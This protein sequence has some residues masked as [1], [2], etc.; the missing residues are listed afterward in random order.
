MRALVSPGAVFRRN[1]PAVCE[2]YRQFRAQAVDPSLPARVIHVDP[3]DGDNRFVTAMAKSLS[4]GTQSGLNVYVH[5]SLATREEIS[6]SDFDALAILGDELFADDCKLAAIARQLSDA[7]KYM[8]HADPLQHHGW[9]VLTEADLNRY[10]EAYF[11]EA[12]FQYSRSLLFDRGRQLTIRKRDS[13]LEMC[14]AFAELAAACTGMLAAGQFLRNAYLTKCVLS[15]FMLLPSL[16]VQA[17]HAAGIYKKFSFDRARRDFTAGEWECMDRV[18]N[19]RLEWDVPMGRWS[20]RLLSVTGPL[21]NAIVRNA[22]PA[23]PQRL[24]LQIT[25]S[26][27][28]EMMTLIQRMQTSVSKTAGSRSVETEQT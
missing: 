22:S 10:C 3:Y 4:A 1:A 23:L 2:A 14:N 16:Y 8:F 9:F 21:R 27:V 13:S 28:G 18:S 12:L 25:P 15:Q 5:G 20:Q 24:R 11:P 19:L 6:Y 26:L 7:R 17:K